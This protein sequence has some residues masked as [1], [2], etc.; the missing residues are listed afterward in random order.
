MSEAHV[1]PNSDEIYQLIK[2]TD[3]NPSDVEDVG[4]H[5]VEVTVQWKGAVLHVAHLDGT[6]NFVLAT[7]Q[8]T[9]APAGA[10]LLGGLGA[11]G[12]I[13]TAGAML[14]SYAVGAVGAAIA[15]AGAGAGIVL[16]QK[17][18]AR[19]R[20]SARFIV[21]E[22]MLGTTGEVPIVVNAGGLTRFVLLPGATGTLEM[23]GTSRDLAA[24]LSDGTAHAS[25]VV[26]GAHE[27]DV[28]ADGRCRMQIGGLTIQARVVA[29][30]KA[31]GRASRRDAAM[32]WAGVGSAGALAI[33]MVAMF[34]ASNV[35]DARLNAGGDEDR[36]AA[37]RGF[38][39]RQQ[40]R[41]QEQEHPEHEV[42]QP[43]Q[44]SVGGQRAAGAEGVA[45]ARN[46][47][48]RNARLAVRDRGVTAQLSRVAARE[49]VR[50]RGVFEGLGPN[51]IAMNQYTGP[52]SIFGGMIA[53]GADNVDANG[54]IRGGNIGTAGGYD[55]LGEIGT[56]EGGG[57]DGQGTVGL[58]RVGTIGTTSGDG[59]YGQTVARR[60]VNREPTGPRVRPEQPTSPGMSPDAIRRVVLR[61]LGQISHCHEQGL[62]QDPQLSGRV[63]VRFVIGDGG[64]VLASGVESSSLSVPSTSTCIAGAVRR[65]Q[66]PSPPEQRSVT[67]SYPFRLEVP[68]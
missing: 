27:I 19:R 15:L 6:K 58:D 42:T 30:A 45:G 33:A 13:V 8:P 2:R 9:A 10:A 16:D 38:L 35:D 20:D 31:V 34:V 5:A 56:G 36:L 11:G 28:R 3:I 46:A 23:G 64:L 39:Q 12:T 44:G 14:G 37:L 52:T 66:F 41:V 4:S 53:S 24:L 55:A 21:D 54:H 67:V 51:P 40:D 61:N 25:Q 7:M 43:T 29:R 62:A 49:A 47:P 50:E 17:N 63:V 68:Q 59:T 22:E 48:N 1:L 32:M 60:L 57:G 26:P 18:T 65:W